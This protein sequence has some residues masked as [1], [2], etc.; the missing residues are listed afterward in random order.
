MTLRQLMGPMC[1]TLWA[2]AMP[3]VPMGSAVARDA[4]SVDDVRI[5]LEDGVF[6]MDADIDYKFSPEALEALENGVPLTILVHI[7][8]RGVDAWIW[9]DNAT[10]LQLRYAIRYKPLSERYEVYRLPGSQGRGF[11]SREAAIAAL[12]EIRN[13]QLVSQDRLDPDEAYE[14][15][16]KVALDIEELPLPLRPIAYMRS[17]WKLDSS[18][19]K[20]PITP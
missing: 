19:T 6:V 2:L 14:A 17:A 20:W 10:D 3:F 16:I 1:L 18:W 4:F 7:Q 12:G 13:L 11:V 9:E 5:R 8:V 15:Q